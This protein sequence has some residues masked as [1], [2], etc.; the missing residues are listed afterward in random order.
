MDLDH[1]L[2]RCRRFEERAAAVYRAYAAHSR[3]DPE[4]C[5]LWTGL[6]RD[7]ERHALAIARARTWLERA[8]GWRTNLDG[9]EEALADIE[10]RVEAAERVEAAGDLDSQLVASLALERSELDSLYHRLL[11]VTHHDESATGDHVAPL[12]A[13]ADRRAANPGVALGAALLRARER[14][15]RPF[16]GTAPATSPRP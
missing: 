2:A 7:E 12:L 4:T 14:L 9:W 13:A 16:H 10:D 5:A 15:A 8:D 3:A 6:A 11:D 1:L